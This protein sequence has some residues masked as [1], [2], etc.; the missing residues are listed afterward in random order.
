[1]LTLADIHPGDFIGATAIKG[2]DGKL[3]AQ[4]V[5]IFPPLMHGTGE[6]LYPIDRRARCASSSPTAR[7]T[8]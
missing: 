4:G 7:S 3:R 6:G 8:R 1:M 5:R 2:A